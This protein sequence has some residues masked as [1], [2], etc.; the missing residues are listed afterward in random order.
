MSENFKSVLISGESGAGKTASL[1]GLEDQ[2]GVLYLNC[3]A[4]KPLPFKNKFVK[5][6]IDDP[7]EL[8]DYF[9]Y[10]AENPN[11]FHT[12]IIDT[13]SFLMDRYEAM[14]VIPA[15]DT[16]KAWGEL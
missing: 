12:V 11:K 6:T 8:H 9:D 13:V 3:E 7:Y 4:G 1:M 16:Q 10:I 14:H 2:K 5:K 15:N